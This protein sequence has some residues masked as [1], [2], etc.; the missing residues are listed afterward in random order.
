M[1]T[2]TRGAGGVASAD[3]TVDRAAALG[4][5]SATQFQNQALRQGFKDSGSAA[6]GVQAGTATA[7]E[8]NPS[9][10]KRQVYS[11]ESNK[12]QVP[13]LQREAGVLGGQ[14]PPDV[15]DTN[16]AIDQSPAH[17]LITQQMVKISNGEDS[18]NLEPVGPAQEPQTF[19]QAADLSYE[20]QGMNLSIVGSQFEVT[21][22]HLGGDPQFAQNP[23]DQLSQYHHRSLLE[24]MENRREEYQNYLQEITKEN[25][26][27]VLD[28]NQ[29]LNP[30]ILG[31]LSHQKGLI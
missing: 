24:E 15:L 23:F 25:P 11:K 29:M 7:D 31:M 4:N 10:N 5:G 3:D 22:S 19:Q 16:E 17:T 26:N 12:I 8:Q 14:F 6:G 1:V 21:A 2:S 30:A 13:L 18:Q 9:R 20:H 27:I 28:Q